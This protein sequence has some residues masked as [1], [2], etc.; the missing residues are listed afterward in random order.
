MLPLR[1]IMAGRRQCMSKPR[2]QRVSRR[3]CAVTNSR[4]PE[5]YLWWPFSFW[6]LGDGM[7]TVWLDKK[8]CMYF[9]SYEI[10]GKDSK[11]WILTHGTCKKCKS[12]LSLVK[13]N[14]ACKTLKSVRVSSDYTDK[15]NDISR[16]ERK[17][18]RARERQ[19]NRLW[20]FRRNEGR[21]TKSDIKELYS[22]QDGLCYYCGV[23][24]RDDN[25]KP[26]FEIDHMV[27]L[28]DGGSEWPD[29][30]A[31]ACRRCN[32]DK[33]MGS[34]RRLRNNLYKNCDRAVIKEAV[35]RSKRAL[36]FKK[37]LADKRR[38]EFEDTY[39]FE[40]SA[41][42]LFSK[43]LPADSEISK[44]ELQEI[45]SNLLDHIDSII[46]KN[47]FR[48]SISKLLKKEKILRTTLR[49]IIIEAIYE[50]MKSSYGDNADFKKRFDLSDSLG[51][52]CGV[53]LSE[54]EAP[55]YYI[56]D[57]LC[58]GSG[59]VKNF[60][61]SVVDY[62]ISPLENRSGVLLN[63]YKLCVDCTQAKVRK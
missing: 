43:F 37:L 39:Y 44:Y 7:F 22:I 42:S 26:K 20:H 31:L 23:S 15:L 48:K 54:D 19:E 14:C 25:H 56:D 49:V 8:W 59:A 12:K 50:L 32:Q 27:A 45:I 16:I 10:L 47:G 34:E 60:R 58:G 51:W 52:N 36:P 6:A 13:P 4:S 9:D 55:N 33:G 46:L 5:N 30:L 21:Y 17:R 1:P 18:E 61:K 41:F 35:E 40:G 11:E 3:L 24:L 62:I 2:G 28:A 29:N 63:F 57:Q 38:K 53:Y